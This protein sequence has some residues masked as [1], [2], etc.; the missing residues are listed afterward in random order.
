M[1]SSGER[2]VRV[3]VAR[4]G[5]QR[6]VVFQRRRGR[7]RR[8]RDADEMPSS[9]GCRWPAALTLDVDP[10][11][12]SGYY[13]VVMEIDVGREGPAGLR[14]LRRPSRLRARAS[15]SR[16]RRTP[17]TPTTTSADRTSTP[18]GPTSPCSGRWR[19]GTCTSRPARV[20]A[21]RARAHPIRRTPPTS[22]T[23]DQPPV[24]LRRVGG[25]ARLGAAVHRVGR[26][27]G[28]R[29][30]R[31]HQCRPGGAPRGAAT[32]PACISRSA[33]TS[34]G[35]RACG[36]RWRRSSPAVGTRPSSRATR[37]CGRCGSRGTSTTSWSGTRP[38]SRTTR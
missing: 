27:P 37:R 26:A 11:W 8:A 12:R 30:R 2:P 20:G 10:A 35:P 25:M 23:S 19:R 15:S 4:I 22:A 6:E 18:E 14:V 16:W 5:G 33:T 24:G 32:A 29:H 1:S 31:L 34:T 21:S 9:N 28:V 7:G 13:E 38:S 36:T 3:E 17:G